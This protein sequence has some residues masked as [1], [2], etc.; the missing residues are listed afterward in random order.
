MAEAGLERN[1]EALGT[2][3]DP[4]R[5]ALYLHV[6]RAPED[7]G[8]D[9]A[10][11]AVGITRSLAAFHL[12][13]LVADGL[14][15]A[16]YRRLSGRSGP[17]AGRPAKVYRPKGTIDVQIPERDYRLAGELIL[18]GLRRT[19]ADVGRKQ[20][21]VARDRGVSLGRDA[22]GEVRGRKTRGS[23]TSAVM[24]TLRKHGFDPQADRPGVIGLRNCPFDALANEYPETIC[25]LNRAFL[26]GLLDG[27]GADHLRAV[28]VPRDGGCCVALQ[29]SST[30]R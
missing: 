10:A 6:L 23:L 5:R 7:V 2:L 3:A 19:K 16:G 1:L 27:L 30:A 22:R 11:A 4:T 8:R 25:R 24:A 18:E 9:S 29:A 15:E 17:G 28:G 21:A 14:L 13:R 20:E 12:D 26:Q